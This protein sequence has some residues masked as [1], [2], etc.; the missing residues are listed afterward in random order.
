MALPADMR[1]FYL[2][3]DG[4]DYDSPFASS[5]QILPIEMIKRV[6][7]E[8][9]EH[10]PLDAFIVG[11]WS[12]AAHLYAIDLLGTVGLPGAVYLV[13]DPALR[14]APTFAEFLHQVLCD[15]GELFHGESS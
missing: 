14:V 2:A 7:D 9:P 12:L 1:A 3:V 4:M 15:A 5:V 6:R 8:Y 10:R 13:H 11:D